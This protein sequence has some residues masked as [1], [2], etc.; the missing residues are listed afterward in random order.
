MEIYLVNF[1]W[2]KDDLS[3]AQIWRQVKQPTNRRKTTTLFDQICEGESIQISYQ[4]ENEKCKFVM[5]WEYG[6]MEVNCMYIKVY[7]GATYIQ[8]EWLID[9]TRILVCIWRKLLSK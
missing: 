8:T 9:L 1:T 7:L 6:F 4:N 2:H 5:L 3:N